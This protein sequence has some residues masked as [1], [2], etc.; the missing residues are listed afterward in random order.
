MTTVYL[1]Y[2]MLRSGSRSSLTLTVQAEG[3]PP[4][5]FG[6]D[7]RNR[8]LVDAERIWPEH[9]GRGL[10]TLALLEM[11][12]TLDVIDQYTIGQGDLI[13]KVAMLKVEAD[14]CAHCVQPALD[15]LHLWGS[16]YCPFCASDIIDAHA[17]YGMD[18]VNV[19]AILGG[20]LQEV[21]YASL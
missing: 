19:E 1:T 12:G 20:E 9:I 18:R 15:L 7:S 8:P 10:V 14:L 4:R 16:W 11:Q 3:N 5:T 6:Y 2:G 13:Y 21:E 17:D